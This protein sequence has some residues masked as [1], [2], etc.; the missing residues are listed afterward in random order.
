MSRTI[1]VSYAGSGSDAAT[2]A[3]FHH[4]QTVL[5]VSAPAG[6]IT[7]IVAWDRRKL[8][9]T[10]FYLENKGILH[11]RRGDGYWLWKPYIIL[12]ALKS[13]DPDDVVVYWDAGRVKPN[14]FTRP[15]T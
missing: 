13:A 5:N 12:E 14:A 1:L 8:E 15:I 4:A 3:K 7:D 6:G 10:A 9:E 2:D 11:C